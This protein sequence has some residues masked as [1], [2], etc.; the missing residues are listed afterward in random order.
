M[1]HLKYIDPKSSKG[2][3]LE[4]DRG[5]IQ[6]LSEKVVAQISGKYPF[7]TILQTSRSGE[8]EDVT[9]QVKSGMGLVQI[10]AGMPKNSA[11]LI[12]SVLANLP[13][14]SLA[15]EL[16]KELLAG[17]GKLLSGEKLSPGT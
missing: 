12:V 6:Q 8:T 17:G 1:K 5:S 9:W 13:A 3:I 14:Q 15:R 11:N 7:K 2:Y 10:E 16:A 4:F